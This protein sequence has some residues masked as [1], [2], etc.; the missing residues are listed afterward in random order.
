MRSPTSPTSLPKDARLPRYHQVRDALSAQIASLQWRPDEAI[1]TE[2]E[3]A[4][5]HGVSIGTIRKAVDSL[6]AGGVLE[7]FPGRGTFVRRPDFRSS[8]FRFFRLLDAEGV[9]RVP[10]S[11][12]LKREEV[13]M[14]ADVAAALKLAPGTL[15]IRFRRLRLIDNRPLLLEDIWL[16]RERFLPLLKIAPEE[17]GDL[18][19]PIYERHCG[20]LV[21]SA[22]ETL[23]AETAGARNAR[24]LELEP[25]APVIVIERVALGSDRQPIEW[26]QSRG[27]ADR[28]RYQVEIR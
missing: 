11:R 9:S 23:S 27:P 5:A 10:E 3:L 28:F 25:G 17:F 18:L 22:Q 1:P 21:A 8:L 15:A 16:P 20:V 6:V 2:T 12:I 19:Y 24:L 26:R 13:A 4:Q 14:P 7:R